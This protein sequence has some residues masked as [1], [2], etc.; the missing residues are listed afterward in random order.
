MS[1]G[2]IDLFDFNS[3][4]FHFFYLFSYIFFLIIILAIL[5]LYSL[6]VCE[7]SYVSAW[8]SGEKKFFESYHQYVHVTSSHS[9]PQI[10]LCIQCECAEW[11]YLTQEIA[12]RITMHY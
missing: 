2:H 8:V 7:I 3:Y 5:F 6:H 11:F 4:N 1:K 12:S 9:L 10:V